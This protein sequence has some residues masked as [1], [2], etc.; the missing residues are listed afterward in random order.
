MLGK[1]IRENHFLPTGGTQALA[2][3][4]EHTNDMRRG[5]VV[6]GGVRATIGGVIEFED[7]FYT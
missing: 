6:G 7:D 2:L 5:E 1:D 3:D 4:T